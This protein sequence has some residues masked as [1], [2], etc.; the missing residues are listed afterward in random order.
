MKL[1]ELHSSILEDIRI[2][3]HDHRSGDACLTELEFDCRKLSTGEVI[4]LAY[5]GDRNGSND[6]I[7]EN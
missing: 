7:R 2:L 4:L 5:Y 6:T 3:M 1:N